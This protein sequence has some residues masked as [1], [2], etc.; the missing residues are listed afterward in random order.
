L[1]VF[2]SVVL[3]NLDF[4]LVILNTFD[5][6]MEAAITLYPILVVGTEC[7]HSPQP[8]EEAGCGSETVS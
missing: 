4:D 2:Q 7:F 6:C 3:S 5:Q 1:T 8:R